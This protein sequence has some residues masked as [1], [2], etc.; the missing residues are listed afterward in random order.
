MIASL[1]ADGWDSVIPRQS[2]RKGPIFHEM[3]VVDPSS[4]GES[5][6][7]IRHAV[8]TIYEAGIALAA[9]QSSVK[10]FVP[11]LSARLFLQDRKIGYPSVHLFWTILL[12]S[13]RAKMVCKETASG[14]SVEF[15]SRRPRECG[16]DGWDSERC[17]GHALRSFSAA[18]FFFPYLILPEFLRAEP[19]NKD[20]KH[21]PF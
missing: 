13:S 6:L 17:P 12:L 2:R 19:E 9:Q 8:V 21:A 20:N 1:S 14:M 3:L 16:G 5:S 11:R 4:E 10:A 18:T 15:S 7:L